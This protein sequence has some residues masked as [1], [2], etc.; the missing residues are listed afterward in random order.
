MQIREMR[1]ALEADYAKRAKFGDQLPAM[2]DW[3]VRRIFEKRSGMPL[4]PLPRGLQVRSMRSIVV[5][6]RSRVASP[7]LATDSEREA[8]QRRIRTTQIAFLS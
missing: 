2:P 4:T 1:S 6:A 8:M 7:A 5:T 3:A